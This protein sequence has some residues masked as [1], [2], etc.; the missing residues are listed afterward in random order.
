M[1]SRRQGAISVTSL[2][3]LDACVVLK[4]LLPDE[5]YKEKADKLKQDIMSEEAKMCAP[6]FMVQEVTNALWK[7][8]KL[9][10]ITQEDA[11]EALK[12]SDDLQINFYEV[13]WAEASDELSIASKMDL[14]VYD[15][16]YL[17]LSEKMNAKLITSDDKMYQ[18]AKGHFRVLHLKDYV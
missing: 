7:A 15:A 14:A 16:A 3:V 13:N 12:N 18:K 11:K 9:R 2:Y 17:F 8:I 10:R 4:W 5:P 6:S 1:D